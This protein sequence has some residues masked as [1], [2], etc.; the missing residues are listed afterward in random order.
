MAADPGRLTSL[1]EQRRSARGGMLR[2]QLQ[3]AEH[4]ETPGGGGDVGVASTAPGALSIL[5]AI[6][7]WG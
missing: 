2:R 1:N 5:D 3:C 6:G 4:Y 7:S